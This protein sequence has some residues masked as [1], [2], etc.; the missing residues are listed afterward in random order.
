MNA[1]TI[2]TTFINLTVTTL[3]ATAA[4]QQ[5]KVFHIATV[6]SFHDIQGIQK[7]QGEGSAVSFQR[8]KTTENK[9]THAKNLDML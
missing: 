2:L 4:S 1:K 6:I 5:D 9:T 7:I 3:D 8:G